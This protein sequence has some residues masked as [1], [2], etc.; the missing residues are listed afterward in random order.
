[1]EFIS[2]LR[3]LS[4]PFL[5]GAAWLLAAYLWFGDKVHATLGGECGS[6]DGHRCLVRQRAVTRS[7]VSAFQ[8]MGTAGRISALVVIAFL[9]GGTMNLILAAILRRF[10]SLDLPMILDWDSRS[11]DALQ[12]SDPIKWRTAMKLRSEGVTRIMTVL[13]LALILFALAF[14]LSLWWLLGLF[15]LVPFSV[16]GYMA[17]E[18][19]QTLV[20]SYRASA[21]GGN[22]VA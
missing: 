22:T 19:Y 17:T 8:A 9:V 21:T 13:P 6:L 18:R 3:L 15:A 11:E 16:H 20:D 12:R 2:G 14:G 5:S 10:T 4:V 1:M 7:L